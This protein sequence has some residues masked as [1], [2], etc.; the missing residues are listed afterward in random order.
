MTHDTPPDAPE[1]PELP[2][3]PA[4]DVPDLGG[5]G[6]DAPAMDAAPLPD[7]PALDM[8]G[9][10]LPAMGGEMGGGMPDMGEGMAGN[11]DANMDA[12]MGGDLPALDS[13]A[14]D[15]PPQSPQLPPLDAAAADAPVLERRED[16][17][18]AKF[19]R[20]IYALPV[21]VDV[22]IGRARPTVT[23][24]LDLDEGSLLA[25]DRG[26]EDPVDLCVDGRVIARGELMEMEDGSGIG[27]RIT[28]VVDVAEDVFG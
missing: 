8:P 3:M 1:L 15:L 9:G 13:P 16:A 27:V 11:M 18:G 25:L 22:V 19:K 10:E 12:N 23:E 5:P 20:S 24:L 26:V 2:D 28:Q 14:P 17:G 21:T 4:M 6:P 7:L